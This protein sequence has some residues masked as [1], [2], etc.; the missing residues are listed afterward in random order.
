M[1]SCSDAYL[2]FPADG[3]LEKV[4]LGHGGVEFHRRIVLP[5][6]AYDTEIF[7]LD[8]LAPTGERV[9]RLTNVVRV[10]RLFNWPEWI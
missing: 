1:D 7:Q 8:H 3:R 10:S 4:S 5:G 6:G 9:Y 2:F